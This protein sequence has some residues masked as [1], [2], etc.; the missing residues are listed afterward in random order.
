[1]PQRDGEA[2]RRALAASR[3]VSA[4]RTTG[5]AQTGPSKRPRAVTL[6]KKR[7]QGC[8][9]IGILYTPNSRIN[10][11]TNHSLALIQ[12]TQREILT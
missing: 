10:G 3:E 7:L 1:M 8:A 4:N 9:D 2:G 11:V 5:A 6:L 12:R